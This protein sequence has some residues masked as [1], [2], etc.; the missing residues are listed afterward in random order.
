M[1]NKSDYTKRF[2]MHVWLF[3]TLPIFERDHSLTVLGVGGHEGTVL[4][5]LLLMI[6][7]SVFI[8]GVSHLQLNHTERTPECVTNMVQSLGWASLQYRRYINVSLDKEYGVPRHCIPI[9]YV[10]MSNYMNR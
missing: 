3:N 10:F 4:K 6:G 7:L 8:R 1:N 2:K 9:G 5:N